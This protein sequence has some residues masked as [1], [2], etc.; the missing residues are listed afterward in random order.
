MSIAT[1]RGDT[2]AM[3]TLI[4]A[5]IDD[6]N[7]H[8]L[9]SENG[10]DVEYHPI[11]EREGRFDT[12]EFIDLLDGVEILIVGFEGVSEEVLDAAEDLRIVACTRGGPDA[13]VDISAATERGIPVLYAPGRNAVSVA[14][15][16]LGLIL[17][18]TRHI[19][20][21]H[22]LLHT[23]T[24]TGEPQSD[25]AAGGEREDVTWGI[26]KGS[27]YVELKGPELEDKTLGIV[28][29]GA[30]GQRVAERA[31]GFGVDLVGYDPYIDAEGMAEWGV[32][33]VDLDEL[34]RSSDI[35]TVHVPVTDAT[36]GLIG[37]EEFDLMADSAYFINTARGAI[38]DQDALQSELEAGTLRG[39]ALDVYDE[40]PLPDDHPLLEMPNVVTTPHLAGA[41]EEV[42]DRHSEMI[43]DDIDA[44]LN[45]GEPAHLAN[46][47]VLAA[48]TRGD[49]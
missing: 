38:I 17:A 27:P 37:A 34:C 16:T 33:K 19:A 46:E 47:E 23:G 13:N 22:H 48:D 36:R 4:T 26:A 42:I 44:L 1:E 31:A 7:L 39:A 49:D 21:S 25:S 18:V 43:V 24:Y 32:E 10:L 2:E 40:E 3:K 41:A 9:E 15:F 28:G 45:D 6:D 5:N 20:H 11:A 8:R 29:L 12:D 35:V 14:D 30:I